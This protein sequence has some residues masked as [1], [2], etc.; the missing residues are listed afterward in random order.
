MMMLSMLDVLMRSLRN[1][2]GVVSVEWIILAIVVM[3]AITA[4]FAPAFQTA[5]T[6]GVG[7]VTSTLTS[8][9]GS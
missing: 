5:L 8:Q 6:T 4:A 1:Q 3:L 2:R 7:F 9:A